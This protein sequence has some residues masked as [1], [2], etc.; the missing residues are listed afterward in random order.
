[1]KP[2]PLKDKYYDT[3]TLENNN[4]RVD[5]SISGQGHWFDSNDIKSAV[6]WLKEQLNDSAICNN[7]EDA[8]GIKKYINFLIDKAFEDVT[9]R[10]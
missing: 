4:K 9:K 6:E 3:F 5:V 7:E 8:K 2:E 1:M 10:S